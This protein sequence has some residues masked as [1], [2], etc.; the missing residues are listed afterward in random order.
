MSSL[1][2]LPGMMCDARLFE[3]Q[4]RELSKACDVQVLAITEF[5]S[6]T[7]LAYDVLSKAPAKF[8]LAGLSMGGI[9]AMEIMAIAP[10]RVERLALMD[11]NH[12]A[13]DEAVSK[14]RVRQIDQVRQGNLVGVMRD[15]MKPL[16]LAE[17]SERD[18]HLTLCMDMAQAL[19]AEVFIRQSKALTSRR[20]QT[21]TLNS[22][23][24][25]TLV[26][27]GR[28]DRLCPVERHQLIQTLIPQA[29]LSII[30]NAGHLP[31]LENPEETNIQLATWLEIQRA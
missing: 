3:P 4:I 16:Y 12:L 2:L 27:C 13:E 19:G 5:D 11:T 6:V 25:P 26:M 9:V 7:E 15:E 21:S 8:S 17:S 18:Q 20:D 28:E 14:N 30:N 22:L 24:L 1:V 31:T 10:E 29:K 23:N